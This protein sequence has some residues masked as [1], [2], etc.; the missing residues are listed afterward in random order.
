MSYLRYT[1]SYLRYTLSYLRY[2]LSYL[3]GDRVVTAWQVKSVLLGLARRH[4]DRRLSD[5]PDA[6]VR[7][8]GSLRARLAPVTSRQL[9]EASRQQRLGEAAEA[10]GGVAEA[11]E[12]A[13]GVAKAA[14]AEAAG[15]GE[16]AGAAARAA[17]AV[18]A[19]EAEAEAE[20][21]AGL[22]RRGMA[23]LAEAREDQLSEVPEEA[24]GLPGCRLPGSSHPVLSQLGLR[25]SPPRS[26]YSGKIG[27]P[28]LGG[29]APSSEAA[30]ELTTGEAVAAASACGDEPAPSWAEREYT[31][32][33]QLWAGREKGLAEDSVSFEA[34]ALHI[35]EALREESRT[36][37]R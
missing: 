1:L 16:R 9:I 17:R 26:Y 36:S 27:L 13:G 29:K 2:T 31:K 6:A 22:R 28:S 15:G 34:E 37:A 20:A 5:T 3:R 4:S 19:T 35:S 21:E 30:A 8:A 33:T 18:A 11:A 12:A 23:G 10:A 25:P 14:E 24:E 32:Y 7:N